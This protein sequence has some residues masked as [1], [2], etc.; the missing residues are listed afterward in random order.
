MA[1]SFP[2]GMRGN[3]SSSGMQGGAPVERACDGRVPCFRDRRSP[4]HSVKVLP[5]GP[6]VA[7]R[8]PRFPVRKG[9]LP[10][11]CEILSRPACLFEKRSLDP[12]TSLA[13]ARE[14]CC[15]AI[16][17]AVA[18]RGNVWKWPAWARRQRGLR[19]ADQAWAFLTRPASSEKPAAPLEPM[20][21]AQTH[22]LPINSGSRARSYRRSEGR[23][24]SR[25]VR[26][27]CRRAGRG[28]PSRGIGYEPLSRRQSFRSAMMRRLRSERCHGQAYPH[29]GDTGCSRLARNH[30]SP[31]FDSPYLTC[32]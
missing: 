26:S 25:F 1:R 24:H 4:R 8:S 9:L 20:L 18:Q 3:V 6:R 28:E 10:T 11:E 23:G 13:R 22:G 17:M 7:R 15:D 5:L 31:D 27:C 12:R 29:A 32:S 14:F 21:L 16:P 30:A 2:S 19:F